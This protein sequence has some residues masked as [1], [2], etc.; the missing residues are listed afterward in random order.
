MGQSF[1]R[2]ES[3]LVLV[4]TRGGE[5][6][7]MRRAR[8]AD[9]WQSVTGSLAWGEEPRAAARRELFEE[10]GL[11]ADADLLDCGVTNRFPIRPPWRARYDPGVRENTEYVFRVALQARRPVTLNPA[12]HREYVWLPRDAAAARASSST[13]RDAILAFVPACPG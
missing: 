11:T 6:L 1:K 5:V 3:V 13:N 10:T 9:F 12:E 8:P 7:L 2:P 4:Y